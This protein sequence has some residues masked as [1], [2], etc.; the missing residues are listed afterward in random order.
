M[1]PNEQYNEYLKNHISNVQKAYTILTSRGVVKADAETAKNI[2]HHDE[3]KYGKEEWDAYLYKFYVPEKADALEFKKAWLHHQHNNPHHPQYWCLQ[4]DDH[5]GKLECI[6]IP[7]C[8]IVEMICDW[9]S[10]SLAKGKPQEIQKWYKEKG[11]TYLMSPKTRK[12]VEEILK[13]IA[14]IEL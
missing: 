8:Y 12:R 13:A 11:S 4:E 6:D 10:F 5:P 3:S 1:T 14:K 9:W 2:A 7:E